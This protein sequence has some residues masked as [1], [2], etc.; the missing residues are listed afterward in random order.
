MDISTVSSTAV[1]AFGPTPSTVL[2]V[3]A[4][5]GQEEMEQGRPHV[6]RNGREIR[7]YTNRHHLSFPSF[8][9]T[10]L[11]RTYVPP[12]TS[13]TREQVAFWE[14]DLLAEIARTRP[15]LII[16]LGAD[17]CKFFLGPCSL[18]TVHGLPHRAGTFDP[19][20]S[21]RAP[22][23]TV[24]L[25]I[26]QPAAGFHSADTRALIDWDF[27][28][29]KPIL[30][31]I[32]TWGECIEYR[33]DE[34]SNPIY[35]DIS[36]RE[37]AAILRRARPPLLAIDTEGTASHPFSLQITIAPGSGYMLRVDREDFWEGIA[38][39]QALADSETIFTGHNLGMY[40]LEVLRH[41]PAPLNLFHARCH[42]TL[43]DAFL[44]C[45]EPLGL[46]ALAWR[47]LSMRMKSHNET[48]GGL[49]R[50]LQI[51]YLRCALK[52][53]WDWPPPDPIF[54]LKNDNSVKMTQPK[55]IRE[56]IKNILTMFERGE[57]DE[58]EESAEDK[59]GE[60]E[61]ELA[62]VDPYKK[63]R[64]VRND[65]RVE[66]EKI[67]GL[68]GKMPTG[69][70][71]LLYERDPESAVNYGCMDSD[72]SFRLY[73]PFIDRLERE[74]KRHLA[75]IYA[76]NMHVFSAM[77]E[78]GLPTRRS[79]I[80]RL[81]DRMTE[82]M[83]EV[84]S[85]ISRDYNSSQPYN[86][87]SSPQTAVLFERWGL[88]GTKK[89]KL[90]KISYGK[91]S[92]QHLQFTTPE[93]RPPE[94]FR[95]RLVS[96]RLQWLEYQHMRDSFCKPVLMHTPEDAD[97]CIA[98]SQLI[99]WGTQQARL[100]A[101][102][103][104]ILA[105]E[106]WSDLGHE[107]RDCFEAPPGYVF[108]ESDAV[109]IEVCVL[110]DHSGDPGLIHNLNTPG[111]KFHRQTA[112][113]LF[114]V[115]YDQVTTEPNGGQ[116]FVGKRTIF[117]TFYGGTG[118]GLMEQLWMQGLT[119]YDEIASQGFIDGVKFEVY[120][121]IG[122]YEESVR[123]YL[124]KYGKVADWDGLE[125]YLP[126]IW[127]EDKSV[128]AEAVRQGVSLRISGGAQR[129][130]QRA[131]SWLKDKVQELVD[132]GIDVKWRLTVHDSLLVTCPEWACDI[133]IAT[134]E[135]GLTEHFGIKL[136]VKVRAESK[137]GKTWGEL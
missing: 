123:R 102:R 71:R 24:I 122:R 115:P 85:E 53:V 95:R 76:T 84:C 94:L 135:E 109:S 111:V 45:L 60:V 19:S 8:R 124:L 28:Q 22:A 99:P 64:V 57:D 89:T 50:E 65:L 38:T 134:L 106:K 137:V 47:H 100:A 67:E 129:M 48:V 82:R 36:G 130:L 68:M 54:E 55:K 59:V 93:M 132:I 90:K 127:S 107:F 16:T 1:P 79:H 117:L 126:G 80:E 98:R 78:N 46:K 72:A 87:K 121:G 29:V 18:N 113:K 35:R 128:S 41:L 116:Y 108:V 74:G 91:K 12:N 6:G 23:D 14:A 136:K 70:M 131:I 88:R 52:L 62:G 33:E 4:H 112:S 63:W 13:L 9:L 77:Q 118:R 73:A 105:I 114:S 43:F 120:P 49:G 40:D 26:I 83:I 58:E 56:R 110:A 30:D 103:P 39:L 20:L 133:V 17:P 119:Q 86:P 44:F 101:K 34:H 5:P 104:N 37:L 11:C 96:L 81:R 2:L 51:D 15:S 7:W 21:Y 10:N 66:V 97:E 25:P 92:V 31:G 125:R 3:G 69:T 42:D 61:E 27:S 75:D 32:R